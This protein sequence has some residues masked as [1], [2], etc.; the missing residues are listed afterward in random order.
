MVFPIGKDLI[1]IKITSLPESLFHLPSMQR[2]HWKR[3]LPFQIFKNT[4]TT[5]SELRMYKK[6]KGWLRLTAPHKNND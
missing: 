3:E 1:F 5:G 4:Q 2:T 6:Y